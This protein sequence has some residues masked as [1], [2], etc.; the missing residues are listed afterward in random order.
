MVSYSQG[1]LEQTL[2]KKFIEDEIKKFEFLKK[3]G[4]KIEM[5]ASAM[6][7]KSQYAELRDDENYKKW[8]IIEER[9]CSE[10]F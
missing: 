9:I 3:H 8:R 7:I 2:T 4:D 1:D 10:A 6:V 5:C